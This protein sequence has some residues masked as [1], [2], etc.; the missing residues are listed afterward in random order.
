MPRERIV[1]IDGEN[2]TYGIREL[3][4]SDKESYAPRSVLLN[5]NYQG[6]INELLADQLPTSMSWFGAKLRIYDQTKDLKKQTT[7]IV[8]FQS[9]LI[10]ILSSQKIIFN[11]SGYLR[12]RESKKCTRCKKSEWTLT[13]KGVDVAIAVE[14]IKSSGSNT[15]IILLSS[16]TDLI[17]AIKHSVELGTKV[18]FV[19]RETRPVN[20]I[21]T[22]ATSTR[23][24]TKPIVQKYL[25]TKK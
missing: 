13:E 17:P 12:A 8:Y 15:E 19:S 6:L 14:I 9:K 16:D 21:S 23:V 20:A 24:M 1:I 22:A 3:L 25:N 11:K 4:A 2:L 5:Y 10:N 7:D 18:M